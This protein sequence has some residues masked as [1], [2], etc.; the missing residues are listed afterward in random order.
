VGSPARHVPG[1]ACDVSLPAQ[2]LGN[3][4]WFHAAEY[5]GARWRSDILRG[6]KRV[7]RAAPVTELI[8]PDPMFNRFLVV[9]TGNICRSPMG[10]YLLRQRLADR[11]NA[12]VESAG[13]G[14]LVG[15]PA[16]PFAL[17]V[18]T[19]NGLDASEHRAR[20][21]DQDMIAKSDLILVMDKSHMR[22]IHQNFPMSRGRVHLIGRWRDNAEVADPYRR[23]REAFEQAWRDTE[24]SIDDWMSKV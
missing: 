23:P 24:A 8:A 3:F 22:W 7:T 12:V 17:E 2:T 20:Q 15:H 5:S 18:M 11:P 21:I 10:E 19:D 6:L 14:A 13:I 1:R 16:D 4:I 9:C